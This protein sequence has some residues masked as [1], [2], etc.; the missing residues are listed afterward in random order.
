VEKDKM[1]DLTNMWQ[2]LK[3]SEEEDIDVVIRKHVI[4][5]V[6]ARGNACLIG[7]LI[8]D[9]VI[10]KDTLGSTLVRGW[11]PKGSIS[12]RVLGKNLFLVDYEYYSDKARVL[13]GRPW[14]Y[15]GSLFSIEDF[16]GA[17]PPSKIPFEKAA[18]WVRMFNM[19]LACMGRDVGYQ[20]GSTMGVVE[21]VETDAEGIGWG[22]YLRLKVKIDLTKPILR[23]RH[24]KLLG[25]KVSV[26]EFS[27]QKAPTFML[28]IWYDLSWRR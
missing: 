22:T 2:N 24:I 16:D 20:I 27:I 13:K 4:E 21:E 19:M 15:E 10:G 7:K 8:S 23:G 26:G 18:F 6:V 12:F 3:L 25:K 1:V 17:T 14:V 28:S 5:G 9:C 11:K